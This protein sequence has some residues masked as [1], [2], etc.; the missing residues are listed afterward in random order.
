[1]ISM[2]EF[3]QIVKLRN[4]GKTQR[5]VAELLGIS[6][7]SV[8]RYLK[9]GKVPK[10]ERA[11][12]SNKI[13]PFVG[14]E[15]IAEE[16]LSQVPGLLLSELYEYLLSKGYT[17]SQ[18]TIQRKT[19]ELRRRLKRKE[20][21]FTRS[22]KPGVIMEG[23]FTEMK[24]ELAGVEQKIYLWVTTLPYS[25][26]F[27]ATPFLNCTFECFAEGSV[28]G[29]EAFGGVAEYYRLDNLTPVVSKILSGKDRVVTQRYKEFQDHYG[30]KQDFCTPAKGNEKGNVESNIRH[31][32][33]RLCSRIAL[34][35]VKFSSLES[36]QHY[37][38][39]FCD[40]HNEQT[41][42]STRFSQEKLAPLP[43]KSFRPFRTT[44]AKVNKFS[45][46]NLEKTGHSYSV[47]SELLG[48]TLEIR[49]YSNTIDIFDRG[50]IV[51]S[52]KRLHGE[53]GLTSIRLEHIID[54]L[55]RK[56]GAMQDWEHR[57]ILF[58][59]PVWSRFYEKLKQQGSQDKDYLRCLK[60]MVT[61]GR[62][63]VTLAMELALE[64]EDKLDA[65]GLENLVSMKLDRIYEMQPVD[66]DLGTYDEFLE[67]VSHGC[68][69]SSES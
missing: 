20:V 14:F 42:I 25:N 51:A 32:K 66:V 18:R 23:D 60:L 69:S 61:H 47:P 15:E 39:T 9:S 33:N 34:Q 13:D 57:Q 59:R 28:K 67:E 16:K 27:Y 2:V 46:V 41:K 37:I 4:E 36:L 3:E 58:E 31:I 35:Q 38:A 43:S 50:E 24:F 11:T 7:R 63:V 62:E 17:G 40:E 64:G 48:L 68:K 5:E 26:A 22:I 12:K 6:R 65:P 8:G 30:F 21:Y 55:C 19:A 56:P 52:H 44:T 49:V 54:Q 29:F 53:S 10:Y 45:L 1:M